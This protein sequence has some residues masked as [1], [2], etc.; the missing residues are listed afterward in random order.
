MNMNFTIAERQLPIFRNPLRV[1]S[2]ISY[3]SSSRQLFISPRSPKVIQLERRRI[4][5][6]SPTSS[7]S[8]PQTQKSANEEWPVLAPNGSQ[9]SR[10]L[11]VTSKKAL[12]ILDDFEASIPVEEL[13]SSKDIG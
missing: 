13:C 6:P 11:E 1:L 4:L 9:N 5:F 8:P 10:L 12:K 2:G 3:F 7:T